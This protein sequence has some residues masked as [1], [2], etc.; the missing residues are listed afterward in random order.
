MSM[1]WNVVV[2]TAFL[3]DLLLAIPLLKKCKQLWPDHSLALVCRKGVG[4]F[5]ASTGLVDKVIEV[6]KGQRSTYV[7]GLKELRPLS[8]TSHGR[9]HPKR[10]HDY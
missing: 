2:Q 10:R 1:K 9:N 8:I 5:F 4:S 6:Q 3:G 7:N